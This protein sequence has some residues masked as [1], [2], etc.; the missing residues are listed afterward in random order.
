MQLEEVLQRF[1]EALKALQER[2]CALQ[3]TKGGQIARSGLDV[4]KRGGEIITDVGSLLTDL[5]I[6]ASVEGS[7]VLGPEAGVPVGGTAFTAGT[8]LAGVGGA[9]MRVSSFGLA[10]LGDF[11]TGAKLFLDSLGG[12][13]VKGVTAPRALI[14]QIG[15]LGRDEAT[16]LL[17]SA[18]GRQIDRLEEA[19]LDAAR[20]QDCKDL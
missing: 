5:G 4:F 17:Q 6:A 19:L 20:L 8:F 3:K 11:R 16:H 10:F 14:K 15:T 18:I 1:V 9:I 7:L 13:L 12:R 2:L